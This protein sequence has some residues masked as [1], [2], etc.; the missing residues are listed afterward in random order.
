MRHGCRKPFRPFKA[1]EK[2][3]MEFMKSTASIALIGISL[4][5]IASAQTYPAKSVR[6]IVPFPAGG[7]SDIVG[8]IV[9]AKLTDQLKQQVIVDNRGGAGGSIGT[10]AAVRA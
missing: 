5:G 8:R 4:A 10:E 7:G 6:L 3:G 9:A 2:A 1:G